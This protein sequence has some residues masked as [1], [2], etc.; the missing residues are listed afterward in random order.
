MQLEPRPVAVDGRAGAELAVVPGGR[1]V[2]VDRELRV[3]DGDCAGRGARW[4]APLVRFA[5]A[6]VEGADA[7]VVDD[8]GGSLPSDIKGE[9]LGGGARLEGGE[10]VGGE[11]SELVAGDIEIEN[12][13]GV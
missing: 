6:K 2:R 5:A 12:A 9:G 1:V 4:H 13:G 11:G 3:V 7:G 8:G 10:A